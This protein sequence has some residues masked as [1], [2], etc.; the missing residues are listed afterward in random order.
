MCSYCGQY[1]D[2]G[3]EPNCLGPYEDC[4]YPA[5]H[6]C[7]CKNN[8]GRPENCQAKEHECSCQK[9]GDLCQA[10]KHNP[11]HMTKSANKT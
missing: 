1:F 5:G 2:E 3:C 10:K 7:S 4:L 9:H 11:C 6:N 8:E